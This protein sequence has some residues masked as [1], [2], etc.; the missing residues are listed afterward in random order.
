MERSPSEVSQ[1]LSVSPRPWRPLPDVPAGLLYSHPFFVLCRVVLLAEAQG[2]MLLAL[3]IVATQDGL[4]RQMTAVVSLGRPG[5][6]SLLK[7]KGDNGVS[8]SDSCDKREFRK[9][10]S[11]SQKHRSGREAR[12][13]VS[14]QRTLCWVSTAGARPPWPSSHGDREGSP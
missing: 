7:R 13:R 12:V 2:S 14:T 9:E 1:P 10:Q 8:D 5:L 6:G 3:L 11:V 4:R